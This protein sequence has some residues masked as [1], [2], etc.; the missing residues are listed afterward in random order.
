MLPFEESDV[1][2]GARAASINV[3]SELVQWKLTVADA[4]LARAEISAQ[5]RSN[6]ERGGCEVRVE[7]SWG[8]RTAARARV[9]GLHGVATVEVAALTA[10][11]RLLPMPQRLPRMCVHRRRQ[12]LALCLKK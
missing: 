12:L 7:P 5:V 11:R 1:R 9:V 3:A 4:A 2:V 6:N 10:E 8:S